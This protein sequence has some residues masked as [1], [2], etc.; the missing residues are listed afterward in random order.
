[1]TNDHALDYEHGSRTWTYKSR[2]RK[3][4]ET[5][6]IRFPS[7]DRLVSVTFKLVPAQDL[8]LMLFLPPARI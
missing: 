3:L 5:K 4:P 6:S 8:V 1:M 7:T 2:R